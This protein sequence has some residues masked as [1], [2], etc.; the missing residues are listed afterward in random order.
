[1]LLETS[2]TPSVYLSTKLVTVRTKRFNL[3]YIHSSIYPFDL[4]SIARV[5]SCIPQVFKL[6]EGWNCTIDR[7]QLPGHIMFLACRPARHL[8]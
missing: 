4:F 1:M 2:S 8:R 3:V 6:Y 5:R 7:L